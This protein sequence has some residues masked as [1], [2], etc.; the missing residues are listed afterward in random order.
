MSD[1]TIGSGPVEE[2]YQNKMGELARAIDHFFNE[3]TTERTTGFVLMVFPFNDAG[4]CN[5]MSNAEREDVIVLLR[6]QLS[7]FEGMADGHV[8]H[9]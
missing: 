2:K 6:E 4:R 9:A 1:H 3:N 8:G 7:H 5:Y